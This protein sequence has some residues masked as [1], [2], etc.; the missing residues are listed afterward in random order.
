MRYETSFRRSA[1]GLLIIASLLLLTFVTTATGASMKTPDIKQ[2]PHPR[3]RFEVTMTIEGAP[4]DFDA[5]TGFMQYQV[6]NERSVPES[7]PVNKVR[8]PPETS[9][10]IHFTRVNGNTYRGEVYLDLIEDEDYFGLGVCHWAMIA[11]IVRLQ[12][13]GVT[14]SPDISTADVQG[15]RSMTRY[16]WKDHFTQKDLVDY[17]EAGV[18]HSDQVDAKRDAYFSVTLSARE[19]GP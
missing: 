18:P 11:A 19:A 1:R 14:F 12:V 3:Q 15:R 6:I 10:P 7:D 13:N 9:P 16:F 4:A 2:N 8:I 17:H 5:V